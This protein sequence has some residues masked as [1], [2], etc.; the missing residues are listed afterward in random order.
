[1]AIA[2]KAGD[3]LCREVFEHRDIQRNLVEEYA[4]S[5]TNS[6]PTALSGS[7]YKA[8]PRR[9][10][11]DLRGKAVVVESNAEVQGQG[12]IDLHI[13]LHKERELVLP[14]LRMRRRH[15]VD[16]AAQRIVLAQN[17]NRNIFYSPVVRG[18]C[19]GVSNCEQ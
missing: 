7:E 8:N 11:D 9:Y 18:V 4:E 2:R 10:V 14:F 3:C 13:V 19:V 6:S 1:M 15:K 17:L 16:P 5:A 12:T